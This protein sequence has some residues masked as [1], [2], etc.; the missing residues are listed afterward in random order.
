MRCKKSSSIRFWTG[1]K[2]IDLSIEICTLGFDD[3]KDV[4]ELKECNQ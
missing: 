2:P 4:H 3:G 1:E